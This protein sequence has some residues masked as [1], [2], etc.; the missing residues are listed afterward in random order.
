MG[1]SQNV[2]LKRHVETVHRDLELLANSIIEE[3]G[4]DNHEDIDVSFLNNE[5]VNES[6]NVADSDSHENI[7]DRDS[8][9]ECVD[10]IIYETVAGE[11]TVDDP[12]QIEEIVTEEPCDIKQETADIIDPTT[13]EGAT[14]SCGLCLKQFSN[15]IDLMIHNNLYHN[16]IHV[17]MPRL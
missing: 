11:K 13:C 4:C 5:S 12:L 6:S 9:K 16:K 14:V 10:A 8:L 3:T 17:E 2:H 7:V 1:F 15:N